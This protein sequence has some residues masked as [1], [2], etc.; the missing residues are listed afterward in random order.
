MKPGLWIEAEIVGNLCDE[1]LEYYDDDCFF[2]RNGEKVV[3]FNRLFL[4]YRNKK[5]VDY[6][7]ETIR[8]MVEDYGTEYIKI[9]Y[10]EDPGIGTDL[11]ATSFGEG[12]EK[13]A[14]AF[15]S[16][17]EDMKERFPHVVFEGCASGGMRMD[18]R[19]LSTFSLVS[20]SDQIQYDKYPYIAGNILSAVIPEQ[21]AVWSYPVGECEKHE[22]SDRQIIVNMINS[23]LGRMHLA[24]HL[25]YMTDTQLELVREGVDYYNKL[26]DVKVKAVPYLPFGFTKFD[27]K[28][29]A[30]GLKE[31]GK[32]FLAV[33]N[34]DITAQRIVITFDENIT[35]AK[36]AYPKE[37]NCS[38]SFVG[39]KLTVDFP[40]GVSA[41][42]FEVDFE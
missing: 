25:D 42:F 30:A 21:A 20:T 33:W 34:L 27:E 14:L 3:V 32:V 26:S 6:M 7:T 31:G 19:T 4:D 39:K 23:F 18:Y 36:V 10:N 1:M 40:D 37:N 9:D 29:V 41:A 2:C 22:I 24:S 11:D 13:C 38:Y 28:K 16:W 12:L 35:F 17:V 8:R 15:L 5:V